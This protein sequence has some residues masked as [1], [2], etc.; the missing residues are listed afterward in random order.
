MFVS[1]KS[2]GGSIRVVSL[3]A[4]KRGTQTRTE[5]LEDLR[6]DARRLLAGTRIAIRTAGISDMTRA[7]PRDARGGAAAA[8]RQNVRVRPP[9][10]Q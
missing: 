3:A 6:R 1:S 10:E 4:Q 9:A 7:A 8:G 5:S 2:A